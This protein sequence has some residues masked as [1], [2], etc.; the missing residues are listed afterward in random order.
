[1][2]IIVEYKFFFKSPDRNFKGILDKIHCVAG[3]C[4]NITS[5][6]LPYCQQHWRELYGVKITNSTIAGAG[7][8]LFATKRFK[9]QDFICDY[10]GQ[11]IDEAELVKRYGEATAPYA[12]ELDNNKYVDGALSRGIANYANHKPKKDCNARLERVFD[13]NFVIPISV[14]LVAIKTINE[15]DEIFVYYGNTYKLHEDGVSFSTK[16]IEAI[17]I[18][19]DSE[20]EVDSSPLFSD[21]DSST[22]PND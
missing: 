12:I 5:L 4:P 1:M 21:S 22:E 2:A 9:K 13:D 7:K 18:E 3:D 20:T 14:R 19:S 17:V 15:N 8:G 11:H 6:T 10:Y 16:R